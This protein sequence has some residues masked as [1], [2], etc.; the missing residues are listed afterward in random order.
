MGRLFAEGNIACQNCAWWVRNETD[1]DDWGECQNAQQNDYS[2][3]MVIAD[4]AV[5]LTEATHFCGDFDPIPEV[6]A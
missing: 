4:D 6:S 1:E 2:K 3:A 5:L